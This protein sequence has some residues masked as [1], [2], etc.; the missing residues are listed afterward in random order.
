MGWDG[1][2]RKSQGQ[3]PWKSPTPNAVLIAAVQPAVT[4]NPNVRVLDLML[5]TQPR[6]RYKEVR[7]GRPGSCLD[8]AF[9]GV[10]KAPGCDYDYA[11]QETIPAAKAAKLAIVLKKAVQLA[12]HKTPFV[13]ATSMFAEQLGCKLPVG[14]PDKGKLAASQQTN[15]PGTTKRPVR[16]QQPQ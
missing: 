13:S 11:P 5:A 14:R 2:P 8:V 12:Q 6:L 1:M 15:N 16:G 3:P 9:M 10:Y 4:K 7:V